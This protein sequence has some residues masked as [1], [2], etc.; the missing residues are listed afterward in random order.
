MDTHPTDHDSPHPPGYINQSE[1][2]PIHKGGFS[3]IHG[4]RML[5]PYPSLPRG[6]AD[7]IQVKVRDSVARYL[8][9]FL[10][11]GSDSLDVCC[12]HTAHQRR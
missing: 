4:G 6:W 2:P 7:S 12:H 5:Q 10:P 11:R 1:A 8:L 9:G 3:E